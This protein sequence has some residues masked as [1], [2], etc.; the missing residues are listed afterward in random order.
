MSP[1]MRVLSTTVTT[2]AGATLVLSFALFGKRRRDGEPTAPDEVLEAHAAQLGAPADGTLVPATVAPPM[3]AEMAMPRWRRPSLLEARRTDP[4]RTVATHVR[5]TFDQGVVEPVA[6]LERRR[7][8][9]RVVRLLD[10]PD[11]LLASEIGLLDEGDEVQLAERSGSFWRV[12]C[13]DGRTGWVHRMVLG[14]VVG[15]YGDDGQNDVDE[16]VLNAFLASRA[17]AS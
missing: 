10:G 5:M 13:P 14:D 15:G 12:L 2:A 4:A 7:I 6:G 11:E 9:Y 3:D 16:D 17:Q 8:R 1:E